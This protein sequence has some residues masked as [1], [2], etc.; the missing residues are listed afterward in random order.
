MQ[1]AKDVHQKGAMRGFAAACQF[2]AFSRF[3]RSGTQPQSSGVTCGGVTR[4]AICGSGASDRV[5]CRLGDDFPASRLA[6]LS[7]L[8]PG[9]EGSK[10][11]LLAIN[12]SAV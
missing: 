3:V 11:Q 12:G 6:I 8:K 7:T 1:E 4:R 5:G 9:Q 10:G 2:P